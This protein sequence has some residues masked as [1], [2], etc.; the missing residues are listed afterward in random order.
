[1]KKGSLVVIGMCAEYEIPSGE[2]PRSAPGPL[3]MPV[4]LSTADILGLEPVSQESYAMTRG[5]SGR[6]RQASVGVSASDSRSAS[7]GLGVP[8]GFKPSPNPFMMDQFSAPGSKLTSEERLMLTSG[9]RS[10]SV[11]GTSAAA[12]LLNRPVMTQT[13][14]QGGP[15][16]PM[17]NNRTRSKRGEK[18]PDPGKSTLSQQGPVCGYGPGGIPLLEPVAPSEMSANRWVSNSTQR[19]LAD[20]EA[21]DRKVRALLNKLTVEE[22]DPIS[23]QIIAWTNKSQMDRWTLIQVTGLVFEK[24]TDEANWSEMPQDDGDD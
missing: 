14:S 20:M 23:D 6:H 11:G 2:I 8:G 10:A 9:A 13:P 5:E 3:L 16:H 12:A 4:P 17:G 7:V 15:G 19:K 24:A 18:R 21:V 22:F 1:M